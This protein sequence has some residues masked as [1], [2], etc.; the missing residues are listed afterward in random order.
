M[1]ARL[2]WLLFFLLA[3]PPTWIAVIA[4]RGVCSADY[5]AGAWVTYV[6]LMLALA[7]VSITIPWIEE[8]ID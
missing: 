2:Y 7:A 6:L 8:E 5:A 1:S 3:I 4:S